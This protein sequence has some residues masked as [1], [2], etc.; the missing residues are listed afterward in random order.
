MSDAFE[1]SGGTQA[2]TR[3]SRPRPH[4]N[5]IR[6]WT[7]QFR[8]LRQAGSIPRRLLADRN[9][10]L[11]HS[12]GDGGNP[13]E[14]LAA[15]GGRPVRVGPCCLRGSCRIPGRLEPLDLRHGADV[16]NRNHHGDQPRVRHRTLCRMARRQQ[17]RRS[18]RHG[19][20]HFRAGSRFHPRTQCWKVDLQS[21]R[22][23]GACAARRA[24]HVPTLFRTNAQPCHLR[25]RLSRYST[26]TFWASLPSS[27]L[28]ASSTWPFSPE[29]VATPH[30]LSPNP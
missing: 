25:Y 7:H 22:D 2:G 20:P 27:P 10:A 28:A 9:R 21:R 5:S 4:P 14:P 30:D 1:R 11:L 19:D 12:A 24:A 26:S 29:N 16:G 17:A 13:S 6:R 15:S 23:N 8:Q 18:R 3:P